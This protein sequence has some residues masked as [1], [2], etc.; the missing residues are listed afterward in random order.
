VRRANTAYQKVAERMLN[1]L[2][3]LNRLNRLN[4]LNKLKR[5]TL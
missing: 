3:K 1:K 4:K 5:G 2:N